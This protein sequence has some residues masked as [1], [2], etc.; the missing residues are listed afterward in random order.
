ML[1]LPQQMET[2]PFLLGWPGLVGLSGLDAGAAAFAGLPAGLPQGLPTGPTMLPGGASYTV[3]SHL[4]PV[5]LPV[6]M[7][8]SGA[9]GPAPGAAAVAALTEEEPTLLHELQVSVRPR[10]PQ[11]AQG[12]EANSER[13]KHDCWSKPCALFQTVS[14]APCLETPAQSSP[15][16]HRGESVSRPP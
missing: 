16:P 10:W 7:L 6:P 12:G 15:L 9:S 3:L 13:V 2:T 14:T 11:Q 1:C 4:C 5:A 8:A